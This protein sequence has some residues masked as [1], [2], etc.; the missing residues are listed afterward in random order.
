MRVIII[1]NGVA[2][3]SCALA[4]RRQDAAAHITVVS[5]E[6]KYFYS[7]T[8]LMYAFMDRMMMD[9]LEPYE[10]RAYE[11]QRL[12]LVQDRVTAINAD[13]Q[14]IVLE[15]GQLLPYDKLVLATGAL[16]NFVAWPGLED[17]AHR[18]RGESL[19]EL[20]IVHLVSRQD[21]EACEQLV[22]TARRALVVGGGLIGIELVECLVHHG[23]PTTFLIREDT[24]WPD[25]LDRRESDLVVA[26]MRAH[27]VDVRLGESIAQVE[28]DASGRVAAVVTSK[29]DR[30]PADL[31]GVC[32][33]VHPNIAWLKQGAPGLRLGRGILTDRYLRTSLAGTFA[34]GDCA[35]IDLKANSPAE[36]EA[37]A[38]GAGFNE[39]NWYAAKRQ[40][41]LLALNVLG[42]LK[43]YEPPLFFNS[44]KFFELEF[45]NVGNAQQDA[46]HHPA[47]VLVSPD[48]KAILRIVHDDTPGQ[49]VL[50]FNVLGARVD[51]AVLS[52]WVEEQR[53]LREVLG[54]LAQAQFDVEF[55]RV[56]FARALPFRDAAQGAHP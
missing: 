30:L 49:R 35:E 29:Q 56:P 51:H 53:S 52:Q 39:L 22:P 23:V 8:A 21:L 33:G 10:R 16:P 36:L 17:V 20:G 50:S 38:R 14:Q 46:E 2:G 18:H 44:S 12:E 24:F 28:R 34:C 43:P 6:S 42:R 1:G 7:R 5:K 19:P 3:I 9:D 40:G 25:A 37:N 27:G 45:T 26:H 11:K 32:V 48:N 13:A 15:Q 47:T 54:R 31:L 55:G 41:S 4:L